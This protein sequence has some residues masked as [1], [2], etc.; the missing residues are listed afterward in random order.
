MSQL[1]V[2][3]KKLVQDLLSAMWGWYETNN[4]RTFIVVL[5]AKEVAPASL[6]HHINADD[7]ILFNISSAAAK[8]LSFEEDK[9]VIVASFSNKLHT[10]NIP[11]DKIVSVYSPDLRHVDGLRIPRNAQ[12]PETNTQEKP[13][14]KPTPTKPRLSVVK[15]PES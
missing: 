7:T 15:N 14:Q 2:P 3:V 5:D 10:I 1:K 8:T 6:H 13:P 9:L 4:A 11:W 12:L